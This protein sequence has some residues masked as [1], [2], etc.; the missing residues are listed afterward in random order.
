MTTFSVNQTRQLYV[1]KQ[2]LNTAEHIKDESSPIVGG[3]MVKKYNGGKSV[4]FEYNGAGGITRSDVID[5]D[6]IMSVTCKRAADLEIPRKAV[7]VKTPSTIVAGQDY[8]LNVQI[9]AIT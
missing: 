7:L 2:L 9:K 1:A 8:I 4:A 6:K 5:L 3:I